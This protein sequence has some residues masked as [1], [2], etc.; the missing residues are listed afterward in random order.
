L[1]VV[2]D[3]VVR[4]V[5]IQLASEV[6]AKE[7]ILAGFTEDLAVVSGRFALFAPRS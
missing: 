6:A 3:L 4:V 2:D 5:G 1:D 7:F